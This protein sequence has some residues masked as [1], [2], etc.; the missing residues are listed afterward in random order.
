MAPSVF[1]YSNKPPLEKHFVHARTSFS[2]SAYSPTLV[3]YFLLLFCRGS[4]THRGKH[5][6]VFSLHRAIYYY[7]TISNSILESWGDSLLTSHNN[8]W[9]IK[10]QHEVRFHANICRK[11][12][13][14]RNHRLSAREY[15]KRWV[16]CI[17]PFHSSVW[18]LFKYIMDFPE[19]GDLSWW[20][21]KEVILETMMRRK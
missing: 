15:F 11:N 4:H 3:S 14:K 10:L 18:C 8:R 20:I 16:T 13:E 21:L 5:V 19:K 17:H 6:Q 1:P 2:P 9:K 7:P 12:Q